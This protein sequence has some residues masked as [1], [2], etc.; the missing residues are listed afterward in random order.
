MFL[1]QEGYI[2]Q[3]KI[4]ILLLKIKKQRLSWKQ[5]YRNQK[6]DLEGKYYTIN[7]YD[8]KVKNETKLCII[9]VIY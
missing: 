3:Y 6:I 1:T 9:F 7:V 4:H 2:A 8:Q 5:A